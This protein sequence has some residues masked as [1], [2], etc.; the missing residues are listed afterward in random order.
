MA[1]PSSSLANAS[2]TALSAVFDGPYE[3]LPILRWA[4]CGFVTAASDPAPLDTFTIRAAG[5]SRN[6]GSSVWVTAITPPRC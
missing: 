5:D 4:L 2:V 1:V 6:S 3:V